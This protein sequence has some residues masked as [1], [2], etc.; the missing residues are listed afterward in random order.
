MHNETGVVFGLTATADT[1][2]GKGFHIAGAIDGASLD[3]S[4]TGYWALV[5]SEWRPATEAEIEESG[6]KNA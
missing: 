2:A 4:P 1:E 5:D 6:V 3:G